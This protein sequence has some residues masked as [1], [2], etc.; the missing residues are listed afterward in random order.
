MTSEQVV[1]CVFDAM[2][3]ERCSYRVSQKNVIMRDKISIYLVN[4]YYWDGVSSETIHAPLSIDEIS[5]ILE[6]RKYKRIEV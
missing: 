4:L 5:P 3:R 2:C 1:F 6:R